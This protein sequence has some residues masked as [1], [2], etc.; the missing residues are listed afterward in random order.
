VGTRAGLGAVNSF[1]YMF[2]GS[3]VIFL[4]ELFFDEN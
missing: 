2:A 1:K 4:E 3:S